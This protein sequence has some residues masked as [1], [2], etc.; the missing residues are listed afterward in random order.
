M[1]IGAGAWATTHFDPTLEVKILGLPVE[2]EQ[3]QV[4]QQEK[5]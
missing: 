3:E 5:K 4:G 2:E 1:E